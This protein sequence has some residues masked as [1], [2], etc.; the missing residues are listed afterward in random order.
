MQNNR[1]IFVEGKS[2]YYASAIN[3]DE[4]IEGILIETHEGRPTKIEGN[5]SHPLSLG[6]TSG[7]TQASIYN[8]YDPDR[9]KNRKKNNSDSSLN[10]FKSWIK[11]L[12]LNKSSEIGL[13]FETTPSVTFNNLIKQ[14]RKE[15]PKLTIV[16]YNAN[17]RLN[18]R[19][20]LYNISGNM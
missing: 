7:F 10:D 4:N 14:L 13:F 9:L 16:E 12:N 19:K 8:L 11:S 1:N 20:G 15:F 2:V 5:P 17:S 6:A 18:E 3:N